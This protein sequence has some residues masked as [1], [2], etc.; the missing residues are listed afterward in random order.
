MSLA[1]TAATGNYIKTLEAT[2]NKI[3]EALE[4]TTSARDIASLSKRLTDIMWSIECAQA[5]KRGGW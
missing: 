3:A 5:S 2:R 1:K 4:S